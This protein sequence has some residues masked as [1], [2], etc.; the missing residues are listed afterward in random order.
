MADRVESPGESAVDY[1]GQAA[2]RETRSALMGSATGLTPLGV[3]NNVA[4]TETSWIP[5]PTRALIPI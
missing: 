1:V 2:S 4:A 3:G 5:R